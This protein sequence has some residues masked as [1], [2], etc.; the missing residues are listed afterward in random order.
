MTAADYRL[1]VLPNAKPEKPGLVRTPGFAGPGIAGE[2]WALPVSRFGSFVAQIPAPLGM[3]KVTLKTGQEISG[4]LCEAHA[5][6]NAADITDHGGWRRYT[7][8]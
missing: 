1:F 7:S 6:A 4:F 3:G 8:R 2:V 5:V